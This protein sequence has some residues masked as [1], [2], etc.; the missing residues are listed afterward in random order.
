MGASRSSRAAIV[1]AIDPLLTASFPPLISLCPA[2]YS[3]FPPLAAP[4]SAASSALP[5]ADR[6]ESTYLVIQTASLIAFNQAHSIAAQSTTYFRPPKSLISA[7]KQRGRERKG[8]PE[9]IQKVRLRKWPIS[10]ADFPMTP[11]E[12]IKHHVGPFWE[13]DS[14]ATSGG[15]VFSRPLCFTAE[16]FGHTTQ[17]IFHGDFYAWFQCRDNPKNLF[18]LLLTSKGYLK[19]SV[20]LKQP[21]KMH[22]KTSGNWTYSRLFFDFRVILTSGGYL[23]NLTLKD[24]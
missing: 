8:P 4:L 16:D 22:C 11:T 24:S 20:Y 23:L 10:S 12:R 3:P 1:L 2:A 6:H 18:R 21:Q 13:K 5:A 14:G 9:I 7:E 19:F 17:G 15:P